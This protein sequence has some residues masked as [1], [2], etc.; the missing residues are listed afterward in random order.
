MDTSCLKFFWFY[1][2]TKASFG[3]MISIRPKN[4]KHLALKTNNYITTYTDILLMKLKLTCR[5]FCIPLVF[6]ASPRVSSSIVFKY[7]IDLI[8]RKTSLSPKQKLLFWSSSSILFKVSTTSLLS[9]SFMDIN[10][11]ITITIYFL[12]K[13]QNCQTSTNKGITLQ[14][15]T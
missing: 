9:Y 1:N 12:S 6:C 2:W 4:A 13:I 3:Q 8:S 7:L 15:K 11:H 14:K 5:L 10:Q